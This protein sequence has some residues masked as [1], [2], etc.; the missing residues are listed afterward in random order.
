MG[1]FQIYKR[2]GI[3][4]KG[5]QPAQRT[6]APVIAGTQAFKIILWMRRDQIVAL[7]KG[8]PKEIL[9]HNGANGVRSKIFL[10]GVTTPIPEKA[11]EGFH[12]ARFEFRSEYIFGHDLILRFEMF[13]L[14]ASRR[15]I[16][17][18]ISYI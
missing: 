2:G 7:I 11:C 14:A 3:G 1:S 5:F 10:A 12:A 6:K 13:Y 18:E 15:G 8:K 16:K 17:K 9:S 4:L